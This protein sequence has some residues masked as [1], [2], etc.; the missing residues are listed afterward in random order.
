LKGVVACEGASCR[1]LRQVE[2]LSTFSVYRSPQHRP[3]AA[4]Y[5]TTEV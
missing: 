2:I 3:T 5:R 1:L 4:L